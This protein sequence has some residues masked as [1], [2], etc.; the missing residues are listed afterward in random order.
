MG[1][2]Y[3][4]DQNNTGGS[5]IV[6][7]KVC[8]LV[9]IEAESDREAEE[10][11]FSLGVY[12]NGCEEGMDCECCGDRWYPPSEYNFPMKYADYVFESVEDYANY[13][14]NMYGW[15]IPDARIFYKNGEVKEIFRK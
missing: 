13:V 4:F 15:T 5:F 9:I 1:K 2:F 14:A 6:D 12:Y 3:E 7:D 8:H 11:A 10:K